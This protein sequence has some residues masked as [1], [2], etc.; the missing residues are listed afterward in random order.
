M[1]V[2]YYKCLRER[3]PGSLVALVTSYYFTL[4]VGLWRA[5]LLPWCLRPEQAFRA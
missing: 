2:V 1:I 5:A 4:Y 3:C